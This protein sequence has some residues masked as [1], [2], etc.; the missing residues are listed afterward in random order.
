MCKVGKGEGRKDIPHNPESEQ[1]IA[2]AS[3]GLLPLTRPPQRVR[4]MK[5]A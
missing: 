3:A 2:R 5:R 1:L 4:E